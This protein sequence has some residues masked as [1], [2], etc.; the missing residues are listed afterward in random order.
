MLHRLIIHIFIQVFEYFDLLID[1]IIFSDAYMTEKYR[2][3]PIYL[4]GW[5]Q[6]EREDRTLTNL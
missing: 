4:P 3:S 6:L 5:T 1:I 2:V